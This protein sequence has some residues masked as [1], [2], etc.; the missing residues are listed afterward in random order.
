MALATAWVFLTTMVSS[1]RRWYA[2]ERDLEYLVDAGA[3]L[4]KSRA[5]RRRT[6]LRR[7]WLRVAGALPLLCCACHQTHAILHVPRALSPSLLPS[8]HF[9]LFFHFCFTTTWTPMRV[10]PRPCRR[11]IVHAL[12]LLLRS[13]RVQSNFRGTPPTPLI[14]VL[15]E[16]LSLVYINA[17]PRPHTITC[18]LTHA[19]F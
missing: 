19:L 13:C 9:S 10:T 3:A 15:R 12:R 7:A 17:L 2:T 1:W 6:F 11:P 5:W 16:S 8:S 18:S 14:L 4:W